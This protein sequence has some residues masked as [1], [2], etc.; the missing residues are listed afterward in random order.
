MRKLQIGVMGSAADLKYTKE[1]EKIAERLGE[2]VAQAGATLV[3]GAEKDSD[4]L[5]LLQLVEEPKKTMVLLL[6]LRMENTKI[7]G[8]KKIWLILWLHQA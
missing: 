7:F 3:F 5:I 8:K 4:S 2:L 6:E 1:V